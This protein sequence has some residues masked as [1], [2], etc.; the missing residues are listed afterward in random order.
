MELNGALSNP[1]LQLELPRLCALY[2]RLHGLAM[3]NP[4]DPLPP[5]PR[6]GAVV[7]AINSVLELADGPMRVRE[8]HAAAEELHG[9]PIKWTSVKDTLATHATGTRPRFE[10]A[11]RG[12]YRRAADA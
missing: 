5:K 2:V 11:S 1:R 3:S 7:G 12:W 10:R 8:I 4:R 6:V 9:G